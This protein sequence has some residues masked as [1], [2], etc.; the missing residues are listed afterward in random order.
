MASRK[1]AKKPSAVRSLKPKSAKA[2]KGGGKAG[3]SKETYLVVKMED[4]IISNYNSGGSS[5]P[6]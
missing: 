4:A 1:K 2:V 6:S 3:R 5:S